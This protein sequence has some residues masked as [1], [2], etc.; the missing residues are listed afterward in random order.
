MKIKLVGKKWGQ[1]GLPAAG[2]VHEVVEIDP[3]SYTVRLDRPDDF[4]VFA[5]PD[6]PL[7]GYVEVVEPPVAPAVDMTTDEALTKVRDALIEQV[8]FLDGLLGRDNGFAASV[9]T[10]DIGFE[11]GAGVREGNRG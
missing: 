2:T 11:R 8:G 6:S 4:P 3:N 7:Y 9:E 5:W 1:D 10:Y